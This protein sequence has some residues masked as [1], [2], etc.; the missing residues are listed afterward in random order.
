[1]KSRKLM[2]QDP[3]PRS[4]T[5]HLWL[6]SLMLSSVPAEKTRSVHQTAKSITGTHT[7]PSATLRLAQRFTSTLVTSLPLDRAAMR[8]WPFTSLIT[9]RTER[10]W[11]TISYVLRVACV[12]PGTTEEGQSGAESMLRLAVTWEYLTRN[13]LA[14]FLPK[15]ETFQ[16]VTTWEEEISKDMAEDTPISNRGGMVAGI[17]R[18]TMTAW[19]GNET[20]THTRNLQKQMVPGRD[21]CSLWSGLIGSDMVLIRERWS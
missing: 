4:C 10:K 14:G 7:D 1:M 8:Y 3:G 12:K 21:S 17:T 15:R 2:S 16:L 19:D 9:A 13:R 5:I 18:K 20:M 11:A 6:A